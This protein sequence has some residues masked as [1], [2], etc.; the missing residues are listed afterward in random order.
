MKRHLLLV[1]GLWFLFV[2][3]CVHGQESA[4][5][6]G[7]RII[8]TDELKKMYD[9]RKD[10]LLINTL[11]PIEYAEERIKGSVNIPYS[12]LKNGAAKLPE[13]KKKMLVFYCKGPKCTKSKKT[14][15]LA[16]A[17]GYKNVLVYSEGLPEW[18]KRGYPA[19][20][21]SVYPKPEIPVVNGPELKAMLDRK[22][23]FVLIDLRD[24]HDWQAGWIKG[25]KHI[26]MEELD[27][28]YQELPKDRK[29]VLQCLFGKQG[30]MAARFLASKGYKPENLA[31]LDGGFVDGWLKAGYPVER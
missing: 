12:H 10:L 7:E 3:L 26:D 18:I 8:T 2:P 20:I 5:L 17:M 1:F 6:K 14:A 30:Y 27:K 24:G 9:A 11:S 15:D 31:K 25:S 23:D 4:A 19:D 21:L 13:N 28:R 22:D 29:I 16:V